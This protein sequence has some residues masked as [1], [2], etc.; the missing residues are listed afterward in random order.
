MEEYFYNMPSSFTI[1]KLPLWHN[2]GLVN[3]LSEDGPMGQTSHC[4]V[5]YL[6]HPS[7]RLVVPKGMPNHTSIAAH[8]M[9][10]DMFP[11]SYL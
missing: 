1:C 7:P 8:Y 9:D 4:L 11:F 6:N 5:S 10:I 2:H 3:G